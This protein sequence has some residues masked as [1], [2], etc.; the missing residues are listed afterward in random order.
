MKV[1]PVLAAV[2]VLVAGCAIPNP[3]EMEFLDDLPAD[4][5]SEID[6]LPEILPNAIGKTPHAKLADVEG[7]SCKR[8]Y[9]GAATWED[10][11]RRTKYRA[12][13]KG[14]NAIADLSCGAPKGRSFSTMC[15]ESI[16]CTA[17]AIRAEK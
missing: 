2:A 9:R 15:L 12:M 11:L 4:R 1:P 13:Q 14:A 3:T 17:S 5:F 10:A 16:R 6:A 8:S 7:V